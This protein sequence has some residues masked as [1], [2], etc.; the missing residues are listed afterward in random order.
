MPRRGWRRGP[1]PL[2]THGSCKSS[3][4]WAGDKMWPRPSRALRTLP[5]SK[6]APQE[7]RRREAP[8]RGRRTGTQ[9]LPRDEEEEGSG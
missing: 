9:L 6:P 1:L 2:P 7:R 5:E 8:R 4:T 3:C